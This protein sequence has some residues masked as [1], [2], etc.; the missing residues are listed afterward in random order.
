MIDKSA[1]S[2]LHLYNCYFD[3][4]DFD[5]P[6]NKHDE[7][8][9]ELRFLVDSY[10][11]ALF[12]IRKSNSREDAKYLGTKGLVITDNEIDNAVMSSMKDKRDVKVGED[13]KKSL[14]ACID[15]IDN[16]LLLTKNKFPLFDFFEKNKCSLSIKLA[17]IFSVV[18]EL[19]R[20]YERIFG[21]LQDDISVKKPT[22]GLIYSCGLLTN[23]IE[24]SEMTKFLDDKIMALIFEGITL[25]NEL[26]FLSR[27]LKLKKIAMDFFIGSPYESF[28][29]SII[30]DQ[31][32]P[33][34]KVD[35]LIIREDIK[36]KLNLKIEKMI[37]YDKDKNIIHLYGP[38]G[39]GKKLHVKHISKY[40]NKSVIF[41]DLKYLMAYGEDV[42][43]TLLMNIYLDAFLNDCIICYHNYRRTH[44]SDQKLSIILNDTFKY[45]NIIFLLTQESKYF[46]EDFSEFLP[47]VSVNFEISNI[48]NVIE[49]WESFSKKYNVDPKIDFRQISNTFNFTF[50]QVKDILSIADIK[51]VSNNGIISQEILLRVCREY[52][53]HRL[54]ERATRINFNFTFDDLV[55]DEDQKNILISAC[56][57]IKY[58]NIVYDQWGFKDKV[59]YGRGLSILLYGPPG[60]GKTMGAQVIAN[61][62]GLQ[63][64]KIDLSQ[65][66][67]KY[68]G[69]T[70]KNL[71]DIFT[72]AKKSNAILLFD[73][74][75][76]LFG[77]RTDVK[78]SND[79]HSNSETSFLLQKME[80]YE[81]ISIL[82]T[83]KFN[84]FDEAFRRRMRFI[85]SFP[86]PDI[87]RR[88]MLWG[89]IFP[90]GS[91]LANDFDSNFLSEKFELSGSSIKSVAILAAYLAAAES[92]VITMKHILIALRYESQK[93][94]KNITKQDLGSYGDLIK[95]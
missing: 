79:K 89:K 35:E 14:I 19:D 20:K 50:G 4:N 11:N 5:K 80:E 12:R 47:T 93:L 15:H 39:S 49:I 45:R 2:K 84:S 66:S 86:M 22:L 51:A 34:Q 3:I 76:S 74:A 42:Q 71:K 82:T 8:L 90:K 94:G 29:Q 63:I 78:D 58:K 56:N 73:E 70:Q 67:D 46:S 61:E 16:R 7:Y 41:V 31:F 27:E 48:E 38:K 92:Q 9:D 52:V 43:N 10:V 33:D 65:I 77:K 68:I 57:Y 88:K 36:N 30:C 26:T 60:T 53:V 23:D 64:Y 28:I 17:I 62:L 25:S 59:P 24:L 81:G 18:S 69:E 40:L 87:K 44:E 75:D 1:N 6:Y 91:P 85:V 54:D 55:I 13:I 37:N 72:E 95:F 32:Q 21:Y 83:N